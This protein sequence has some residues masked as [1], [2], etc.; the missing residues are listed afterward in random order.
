VA[1]VAVI[2]EEP[3]ASSLV[4]FDTDVAGVYFVSTVPEHRR[5]GIGS[6]ITTAAPTGA[7]GRGC[8]AAILHATEMGFPVYRRLGFVEVCAL[9]LRLRLYEP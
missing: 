4:F 8:K 1:Y 6:A 5:R 3:V 9:E 7:R 2:K